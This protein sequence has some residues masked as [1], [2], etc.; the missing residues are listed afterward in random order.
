M[1][2]THNYVALIVK[3]KITLIRWIEDGNVDK[4]SFPGASHHSINRNSGRHQS[5]FTS[6]SILSTTVAAAASLEVYAHIDANLCVTALG[7]R[8][9]AARFVKLAHHRNVRYNWSNVKY[10][11][12]CTI[13]MIT[14]SSEFYR[15]ISADPLNWQKYG[16]SV[17]RQNHDDRRHSGASDT[18]WWT[19]NKMVHLMHP[20]RVQVAR[21]HQASVTTSTSHNRCGSIWHTIIVV[22]RTE[23][24]TMNYY[25]HHR[26]CPC[27]A[28]AIV[29]WTSPSTRLLF[30]STS[31]ATARHIYPYK[32]ISAIFSIIFWS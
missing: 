27:K 26:S 13:S 16:I 9:D 5:L 29:N 15:L 17:I 24:S 30:K 12:N 31:M 20:M 2:L 4:S 22:S 21:C 7:V 8:A 32:Y 19:T 14:F 3:T 6:L 28:A 25:R 11:L 23:Q 10:S 18:V 1:N